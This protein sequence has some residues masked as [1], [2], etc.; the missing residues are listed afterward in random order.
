MT[1]AED[2]ALVADFLNRRDEAAFRSLYERHTG[3]VYRFLLR[4]TGRASDAEEGVQET[5]FRACGALERFEWRSSLPTFLAGIAVRW[6]REET[7]R[8]GRRWEAEEPE[9]EGA[10][11]TEPLPLSISRVDLDRA[12]ADLAM[13]YRQALLLHDVFG[14]THGEIAQMLGID[15]GTSKSQLSRARRA[16]RARLEEARRRA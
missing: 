4:L 7:R 13:G 8:R 12:F 5:W 9:S 10:G 3:R 1:V 11:G 2:R 16:L 14:H 6:W 15:E